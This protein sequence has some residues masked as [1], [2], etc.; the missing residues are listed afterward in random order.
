MYHIQCMN[1]EQN[2]LVLQILWLK[3]WAASLVTKCLTFFNWIFSPGTVIQMSLPFFPPFP[4]NPKRGR[5]WLCQWLEIVV[6]TVGR[7][8]KRFNF[9]KSIL[10]VRH[11]V[12]VQRCFKYVASDFSNFF[13]SVSFKCSHTI[14]VTFSSSNSKYSVVVN[15]DIQLKIFISFTS[16]ICDIS[17]SFLCLKNV[18]PC[19]FTVN[20]R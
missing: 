3:S 7:Q 6:G 15:N 8:C 12:L 9:L 14:G 20:T 4:P 18:V 16:R 5:C 17:F 11:R 2:F 1:G 13:P 19:Y 10:K